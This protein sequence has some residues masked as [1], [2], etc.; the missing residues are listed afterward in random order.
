MRQISGMVVRV[1]LGLGLAI[2][3]MFAAGLLVAQA[4][5]GWASWCTPVFAVAAIVLSAIAAYI[6]VWG[7]IRYSIFTEG[8]GAAVIEH[9]R[10]LGRVAFVAG[11]LAQI[12]AV[13][14]IVLALVAIGR[15]LA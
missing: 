12:T 15:A 6:G 4:I 10:H 13:V 11:T 9:E 1:H 7:V 5:Q 3:G 8:C 14:A 2:A